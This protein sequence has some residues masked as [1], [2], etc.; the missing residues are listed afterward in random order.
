MIKH[1]PAPNINKPNVFLCPFTPL[2]ISS[3]VQQ[4]AR[5][6]RGL[7]NDNTAKTWLQL[8]LKLDDVQGVGE[9]EIGV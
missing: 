3:E 5:F 6:P 1:F 4:Y 2:Y 7:N 8:G 9:R